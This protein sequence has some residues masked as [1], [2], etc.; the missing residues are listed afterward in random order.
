MTIDEEFLKKV[1]QCGTLA[2]PLSRIINVLDIDDVPAF[3][4]EFD[5]LT[6][7]IAQAYRKGVDMADFIID[8]KLFEKAKGYH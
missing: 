5:T 3:T 6:S 8:S 4:K 7:K 2:Y 1:V